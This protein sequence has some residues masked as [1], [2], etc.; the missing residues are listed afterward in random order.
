[1]THKFDEIDHAGLDF[2]ANQEFV[3]YE[4]M[5][6]RKSVF[7]KE[8]IDTSLAVGQSK[9]S[10]QLSLNHESLVTYGGS[11][12]QQRAFA[13]IIQANWLE[14]LSSQF[15]QLYPWVVVETSPLEVILSFRVIVR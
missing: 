7:N 5:V 2:L 1:L 12:P 6:F 11:V 3:E 8:A 4:G 13:E 14:R 9:S 10:I 15:P